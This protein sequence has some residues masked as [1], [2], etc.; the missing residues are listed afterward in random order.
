M[1]CIETGTIFIGNKQK[2]KRNFIQQIHLIV[3][4][5]SPVCDLNKLHC[6]AVY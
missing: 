3:D 4:I 1:K 6:L 2:W 5:I